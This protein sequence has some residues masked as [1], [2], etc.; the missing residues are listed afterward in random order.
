[1]VLRNAATPE[2]HQIETMPGGVAVID[3]DGVNRQLVYSG[4]H[5]GSFFGVNSDGKL[6]ILT[7]FNPQANKFPDLY[8]VGIH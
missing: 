7:N 2:K 5:E 1:M 8:S 3:Y 4:P 6:L